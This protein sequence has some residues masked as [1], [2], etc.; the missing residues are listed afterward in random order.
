VLQLVQ[1]HSEHSVR[2]SDT[3]QYFAFEAYSY[4][5]AVPG[6]GCAGKWTVTSSVIVSR[7]I[8]EARAS[9]TAVP[10]TTVSEVPTV[11]SE[12]AKVCLP[13]HDRDSE[14]WS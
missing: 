1:T 4:D 13:E 5:I 2:D 9:S 8:L 3:L 10:T 7:S 11:T 6:E 14:E 12:V